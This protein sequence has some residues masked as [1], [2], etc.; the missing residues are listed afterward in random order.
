[1]RSCMITASVF[2]HNGR[3]PSRHSALRHA[4]QTLP[5]AGAEALDAGRRKAQLPEFTITNGV[6]G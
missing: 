6:L 5:S 4:E 3:A 1:M 2:E